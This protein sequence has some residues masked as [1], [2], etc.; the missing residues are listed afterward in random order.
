MPTPILT[1]ATAS[2]LLADMLCRPV[3]MLTD[4]HGALVLSLIAQIKGAA[5][6]PR[7]E[8]Y[9]MASGGLP[10]WEQPIYHVEN[11]VAFVQVTGTL[12]KGYDAITCYFWGLASIDR[13]Q[14]T[15]L[16]LRDRRDVSAVIYLLNTPGGMSQGM[17]ELCDAIRE[18]DAEKPALAFTSD[19]AASNGYRIAAACRLVFA[20][21]SSVVGCI[22]TYIALYDYAALL[23]KE[24]IKLELFRDGEHKALGIMGYTLSEKDRAFLDAAVKRSG[25]RFKDLVRAR[26]SGVAEETMQ[27]QWFDGEQGVELKLVD[28]TV[29]GLPELVAAVLD[30]VAA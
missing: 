24:G 23:A 2:T 18:L 8:G 7:V 19:D 16:E 4:R 5:P 9:G 30:G 1:T 26:R 10:P 11:G 6:L 28:R 12:V 27:G 13:L 22:G 15:T 21:P 3:S 20:T 25:G 14:E 29:S 17:P